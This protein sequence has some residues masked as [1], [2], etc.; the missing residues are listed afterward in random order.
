MFEEEEYRRRLVRQA[1]DALRD[2]F[3][4]RT[5]QAFWQCAV[6]GKSAAETARALGLRVGSVY[7]AKSRVTAR[8]REELDGLLD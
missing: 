5:W 6:A 3:P 8:L 2:E 1:L 4:E 7:A